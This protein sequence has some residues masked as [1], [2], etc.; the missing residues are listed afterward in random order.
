MCMTLYEPYNDVSSDSE[1]FIIPNLPGQIK[2][3]MMQLPPSIKCKEKT[4]MVKF[5]EEA[6]MRSYGVVVNSFYELEKV[7]ADHFRKVLGRKAWHIGPSFLCNKGIEEK[8]HRGREASIDEHG[9]VKWLDT[10]KLNS[11]VYVCFGSEINMSDSQFRDIAMDLEASGRQ[12]IWVVRKSKKEGLEWLPNGFEKR[13]ELLEAVTAGFLMVTWPNGAD[14]FYN[15]QLVT[16]VLSIGVP[17][18]ATKWVRLE[19]DNIT[20]D[21]LEKAVKRIMTGEEAMEMRNRTKVLA[22][23]ARRAMKEGGSS[24]SEMNALI[25]ELNSLS[26]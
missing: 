19:G 18:G 7:Y 10:K 17:V 14:Q 13:M 4:G 24:S 22:Q 21:A 2:M 9:C 6:E 23:L 15:E 25:E 26:H 8:A 16:E 1:S 3:T 11:V 12:F 20:W 5:V